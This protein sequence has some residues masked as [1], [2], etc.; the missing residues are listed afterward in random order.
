MMGSPPGETYRDDNEA[1]HR[2]NLTQG[3]WLGKHE[4]TQDQW[5][6]VMGS[7][8][9]RFNGATLPVEQVSWNDA[10][11]FCEK[12]SQIEKAAGRLPEG[13]VYTLPTEAQW[14]YGCRAGTTTAYSFGDTITK[15][16]ANFGYSVGK[17]TSVGT[18][19]ANPWGFHDLHGNVWEWCRDWYWDYPSSSASDPV[20]PSD[21][22]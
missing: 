8:P 18:Y 11:K 19:P 21:G 10:M 3:F 9:S 13:W 16:Q 6:K 1:Q 20:G 14:E 4:V 22:A 12:L 17:T 7:N 15:E 2:V 5:K